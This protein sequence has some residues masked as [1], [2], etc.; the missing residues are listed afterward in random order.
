MDNVII[1]CTV[2][3]EEALVDK[4]CS[5]SGSRRLVRHRVL[6]TRME[7]EQDSRDS[8]KYHF[9]HL[10]QG[11]EIRKKCTECSFVVLHCK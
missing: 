2:S 1:S 4:T 8:G 11:M 6:V 7:P 5:C 10:A 9:I 3:G